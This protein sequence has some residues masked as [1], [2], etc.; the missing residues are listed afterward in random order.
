MGKAGFANDQNANLELDEDGLGHLS[1]A[2]RELARQPFDAESLMRS[3]SGKSGQLPGQSAAEL[4]GRG[5][6]TLLEEG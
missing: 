2:E 4:L 5:F 1:A 3:G 6:N